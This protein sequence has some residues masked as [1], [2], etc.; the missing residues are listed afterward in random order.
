MNENGFHAFLVSDERG[1]TVYC[2]EYTGTRDEA[3]VAVHNPLAP[4][5]EDGWVVRLLDAERYDVEEIDPRYIS[6]VEYG[7]EYAGFF[8][9]AP[10]YAEAAKQVNRFA[11]KDVLEYVHEPFD[12]FGKHWVVYRK[13]GS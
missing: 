13:R 11:D 12:P 7:L 1:E 8:P 10:G 6:A 2:G 5:P 9:G 4:Q 3:R